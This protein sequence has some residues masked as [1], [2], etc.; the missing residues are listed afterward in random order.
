MGNE[1]IES[2]NSSISI[3]QKQDGI[4]QQAQTLNNIA[5]ELYGQK[6]YKEAITTLNKSLQLKKKYHE[7]APYRYTYAANHENLAENYGAL[8]NNNKT[9]EH[10][11]LALRNLTN[12][13][14]QKDSHQ[15]PIPN[16]SLY[17]YSL[18]DLIRVLHL[19]AE[20][21]LKIYKK[22]KENN[23]KHLI[24]AEKT[25]NT[26]F[27]FHNQLQQQITTQDFTVCRT[28]R[29]SFGTRRISA[30]QYHQL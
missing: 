1:A 24:L 28:T 4:L 27:H 14:R 9:L 15:N 16:D 11:Q 12:N 22:D 29:Q 13:F 30:C 17:V 10:Y 2:Y 21:A 19:K 8:N 3:Y 18:I 7:E 6:K 25:Y 23:K 26:A 5:V 20:T